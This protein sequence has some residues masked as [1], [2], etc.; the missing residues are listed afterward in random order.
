M[1]KI[2]SYIAC[3]KTKPKKKD[4]ARSY[5]AAPVDNT[6]QKK[7]VQAVLIIQR[8]LSIQNER[9]RRGKGKGK[10]SG[11]EHF[12]PLSIPSVFSIKRDSNGIQTF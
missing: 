3:C 12:D 2:L 5:H 7:K 8:L 9:D 4:G 1:Y 10:L 11:F 6:K